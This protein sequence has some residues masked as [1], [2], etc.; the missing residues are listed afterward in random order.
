[1]PLAA[2]FVRNLHLI[3]MFFHEKTNW[4]HTKFIIIVSEK[5]LSICLVSENCFLKTVLVNIYTWF[6][7]LFSVTFRYKTENRMQV[8]ETKHTSKSFIHGPCYQAM[9]VWFKKTTPRK[10]FLRVIRNKF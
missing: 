1:M 4:Q 8:S 6:V 2:R 9:F 5:E 10:L 7:K 3:N